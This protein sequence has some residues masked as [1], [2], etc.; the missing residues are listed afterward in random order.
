MSTDRENTFT[1]N[2]KKTIAVVVLSLTLISAAATELV[3][4]K[5]MGLGN[6][7]IYD[8]SPLYGYRPLPDRQYRRV[9]GAEIRF[10]NLGL[11]AETDFDDDP[12]DKILFLG[13]SVTY[14]GSR[15]SNQDLFSH[16]ATSGLDHWTSGN[17]AVNA[18]GVENIYGLV[19][20]SGFRPARIYVTVLT[21]SDFYR[22]LVQCRGMPFFNIRPNFALSELWY[23]FCTMQA[24]KKHINWRRYADEAQVRRV[25]AK[26]AS[27]LQEMD[28]LLRREGSRHLIFITPTRKQVM[29]VQ[30][31]DPLVLEMLQTH[32]L[33]ARY[34]ADELISR[35]LPERQKTEIF[36]DSVHLCKAG[37]KLWA[38]VIREA[39]LECIDGDV[40]PPEEQQARPA[41][42][43]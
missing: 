43:P 22:G 35:G 2:R 4:R 15:M 16:L 42:R 25:A 36:C 18:W 26:A 6:P 38:E 17:A 37:H 1:R 13:D 12:N 31:K 21:E 10:N 7:V 40:R 30:D 20:E 23:F 9:R 24:Q 29:G 39:L 3:L 19:V 14:G 41:T 5:L 33:T 11:R 27:K 34:V 28:V 32:G 8:T